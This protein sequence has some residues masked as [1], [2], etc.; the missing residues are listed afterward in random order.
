MSCTFNKQIKA[1]K[2]LL[3]AHNSTQ[4]T[5]SVCMLQ[6]FKLHGRLSMNGFC[7]A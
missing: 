2:D 3:E 4:Q 5:S 1:T 6:N 7:K